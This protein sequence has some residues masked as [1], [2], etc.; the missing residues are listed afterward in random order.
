M[1]EPKHKFDITQ[2]EAKHKELAAAGYTRHG[3]NMKALWK[4][5]GDVEKAKQYLAEKMK[6][7]EQAALERYLPVI[8]E[9]G[10][11]EQHKQLVALG[12]DKPK[13]NLRV[14]KKVAGDIEKAKE[15][16]AKK[17][18][19]R[20]LDEI[21]AAGWEDKHAQL[22]AAGYVKPK[23]NL[24]ALERAKGDIEAAKKWL[25]EQKVIKEK[26]TKGMTPDDWDVKSVELAAAGY[27]NQKYNIKALRKA[28]GDI[29]KAKAIL[30]EKMA[31]KE[32]SNKEKYLPAIKAAGY[33]A[34]H[35][36]LVAAGFNKPKKNLKILKKVG[37]DV[38]KAKQILQEKKLRKEKVDEELKAAGAGY[39]EQLEKLSAAGF[40]KERKNVKILKKVEGDV[41]KA[42]QILT[43]KLGKKKLKHK[44]EKAV[45]EGGKKEETKTA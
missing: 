18:P 41:D 40:K 17:K 24:K 2:F 1:V 45:T 35:E 22:V 23:R 3:R 25:A 38:E 14:L 11:E 39:K 34:Q 37:G 30:A 20:G 36:Q 13:K 42:I 12:Y 33:E 7:K 8:K 29:E 4:C 27:T 26:K 16:L 5:E 21:K 6:K 9:A 19:N 44:K 31:R 32:N 15:K 43:E 10:Y 28:G